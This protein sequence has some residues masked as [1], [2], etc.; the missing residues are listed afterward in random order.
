MLIGGLQ[1]FTALDYPGKIAATVFTVGCNFRCPY[2]HNEE[3]VEIGSS[4]SFD[5]IDEAEVF[6]FLESR[7]GDLDG[8]CIT[9]GEPTLQKDLVGF[10]EKVRSMD[11]LVKIDTNGANF[12]VVKT[13]IASQL[14]DYFA[15]DIKTAFDKYHLVSAPENASEQTLNSVELI[16][17]AGVPLELRT[18]V[19]PGVVGVEDFDNI[20]RMINEKN[21]NI[22]PQLSRYCVQTFRPQKC[23][24]KSFEETRPYE[25]EILDEIAEKLRR[26]CPRVNVIK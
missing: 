14:V 21:K 13:L 15:I 5:V 25:D 7:R 6:E 4:R 9:G 26:Y 10:I 17:K 1:K 18:T 2:C 22:F 19:A 23:L 12:E 24:N 16:S 11:F 3:I 20:V 8:V